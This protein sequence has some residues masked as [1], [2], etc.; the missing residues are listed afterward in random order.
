MDVVYPRIYKVEV[1]NDRGSILIVLYEIFDEDDEHESYKENQGP[2]YMFE[3]DRSHPECPGFTTLM[4]Y[5]W[6]FDFENWEDLPYMIRITDGE[7][8]AEYAHIQMINKNPLVAYWDEDRT[9]KL[10]VLDENLADWLNK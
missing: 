9:D 1:V 5:V 10:V 6:D 4:K 2:N 3:I 7:A 8:G